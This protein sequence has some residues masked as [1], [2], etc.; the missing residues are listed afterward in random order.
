MNLFIKSSQIQTAEDSFYDFPPSLDQR[1]LDQALSPFYYRAQ[2]E[3]PEYFRRIIKKEL[4][5]DPYFSNLS[6]A[7]MKAAIDALIEYPYKP[8]IILMKIKWLHQLAIEGKNPNDHVSSFAAIAR[9]HHLTALQHLTTVKNALKIIRSGYIAAKSPSRVSQFGGSDNRERAAYVTAVTAETRSR[10]LQDI[11]DYD[12]DD[13]VFEISLDVLDTVSWSH[14]NSEPLFGRQ[15]E[16]S[17]L[18][19]L[20]F[21]LYAILAAR[22][23]ADS[24]NEIVS[25]KNIPLITNGAIQHMYMKPRDREKTLMI[26]KRDKI[27]PPNGRHWEDIIVG[28]E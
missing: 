13:V 5:K 18:H 1:I 4:V 22:T 9:A 28:L 15:E 10:W 20:S 26:L 24:Y 12:Q 8:L 16:T 19:D 3:N 25:Y 17:S 11:K 2:P 21:Q 6:T 27:S 7:D 23:P 14:A